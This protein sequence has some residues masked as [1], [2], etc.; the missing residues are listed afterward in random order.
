MMLMRA[1]SV[2]AAHHTT[3]SNYS[4]AAPPTA[5][6]LG[7]RLRAANFKSWRHGEPVKTE[8]TEPATARIRIYQIRLPLLRPR[9]TTT[10]L[11][12]IP[13]KISNP[14]RSP[15]LNR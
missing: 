10:S 11:K 6:T 1:Q 4:A 14:S 15:P 9:R 13:G 2:R 5:A 7:L 12:S 3:A 8:G